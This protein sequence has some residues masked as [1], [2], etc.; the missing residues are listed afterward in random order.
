MIN[1]P[2]CFRVHA[3]V[4]GWSHSLRRLPGSPWL[5]VLSR[6]PFFNPPPS[7]FDCECFSVRFFLKKALFKVLNELTF[8]L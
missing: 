7:V 8:C 6:P 4:H 3:L 5:P 2:Q 1:T